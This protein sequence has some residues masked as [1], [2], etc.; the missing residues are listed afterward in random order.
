[1]NSPAD[2][3][4]TPAGFPPAPAHTYTQYTSPTGAP[5]A[6]DFDSARLDPGL[7]DVSEWRG[8]VPDDAEST[9]GT[10]PSAPPIV[11]AARQLVRRFQRA[12]WLAEA[13]P[14]PARRLAVR[15]LR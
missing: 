7:F 11:V 2:A 13:M 8:D 10:A 1:M 14:E 9:G 12:S 4:L 15:V 5:G 3:P 6:P